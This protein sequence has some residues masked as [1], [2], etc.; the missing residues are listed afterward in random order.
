MHLW[1]TVRAVSMKEQVKLW[2]S[3]GAC[4]FRV[5]FKPWPTSKQG[6]GVLGASNVERIRTC[7]GRRLGQCRT[8]PNV[9]VARELDLRAMTEVSQAN[10]R[11]SRAR[12]L[13]RR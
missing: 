10:S 11:V 12:G 8:G 1:W 6:W 2:A 3:C 4:T 9:R 13:G 7:G 5:G